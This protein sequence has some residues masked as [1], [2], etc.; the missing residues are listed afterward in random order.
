MKVFGINGQPAAIQAIK[1]GDMNATV[2]LKVYAAGAQ[3]AE[4]TPK[5]IA[6]GVDARPVNTPIPYD[7]VT[8]GNVEAFIKANPDSVKGL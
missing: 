2:Y 3:M 1:A 4:D 7:L 6:A 8:Q 5:Y